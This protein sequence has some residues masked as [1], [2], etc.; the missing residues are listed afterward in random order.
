MMDE[1]ASNAPTEAVSAIDDAP[2]AEER[3]E[4]SSETQAQ[5]V[6]TQE[7]NAVVPVSPARTQKPSF[8]R[9]IA[10]ARASRAEASEAISIQLEALAAQLAATEQG[11][12][13]RLET[14]ERQIEDVWEVEEQLSH[15]ME[16]QKKLDA[17]TSSQQ[18]LAESV[19]NGNRL[20]VLSLGAIVATAALVVAS[21][22]GFLQL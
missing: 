7:S 17:L 1:A 18:V 6:L 5:P 22:A 2:E 4:A 3:S 16:I 15:L 12:N 14:V 9:R 10:P 21:A 19:Q 20:A 13:G 11:L 8:W